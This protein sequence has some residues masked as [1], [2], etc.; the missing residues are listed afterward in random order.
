VAAGVLSSGGCGTLENGRGWGQDALWPIDGGRVVRAARDAFFHPGTLVPLAGAAVFAID[1]FD[2]RVSDWAVEHNPIFGSEDGAENA[3]DYLRDALEVEALATALATPSGDSAEE[4]MPAKL[5]GGLVEWGA[6]GLNGSVTNLIKETAGRERPNRE[7]DK[8]FPSGHAS[9]A[10]SAATLANRNVRWIDSLESWRPAI[11]TV[12]TVTVAAVSWA[13]V[14]AR[15]HFPSDVLAGAALGHFL[16]AFVHDAFLNLPEDG[17]VDV[18]VVSEVD[19]VG[20][21]VRV[22]F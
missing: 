20:V 19:W 17:S 5:R 22:R 7:D 9:G 3:S 1:D 8:S 16:S 2:E 6:L 10:S 15:K 18:G 14:E 21:E 13:R 12:N 11:V 4:W